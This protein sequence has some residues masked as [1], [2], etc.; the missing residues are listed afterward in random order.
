MVRLNI[1]VPEDLVLQLKS[2]RNK[3]RYIAQALREKIHREKK[4]ELEH[5]LIEG[6]KNSSPEDHKVNA[7]WEKATFREGWE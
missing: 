2:V 4:Q 7:E 6:Y 3:S 1:T 5:L